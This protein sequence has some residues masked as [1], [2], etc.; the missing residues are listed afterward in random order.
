V[1]VDGKPASWEQLLPWLLTIRAKIGTYRNAVWRCR[2]N[3]GPCAEVPKGAELPGGEWSV[4]P[5]GVLRGIQF[6][7]VLTLR[8]LG[9]I[10]P[11]SG[12]PDAFPAWLT[13]G[14][15]MLQVDDE[16]RK[17]KPGAK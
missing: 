6:T 1:T 7:T 13:W 16:R 10:S 4:C 5:Y 8:D 12:W 9:R 15:L 11:L 2:C 14:L 17:P 3:V